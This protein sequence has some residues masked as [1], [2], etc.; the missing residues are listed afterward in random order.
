MA[1]G[2]LDISIVTDHLLDELRACR[3]D[4]AFW[5][6][7]FADRFQITV[8]GAAPDAVPRDDGCQLG[9]YLFH[10]DV[11]RQHRNSFPTGGEAQRVPVQPMALVLHYL[12]SAVSS[13]GYVDEQQAMSIGLKCF[14]ERPFKD[15]IAPDGTRQRVTITLDPRTPD[16]A[17]R[18]WQA[19]AKPMR[20]S[21]A[22]RVGVTLLEPP[23]EP[24]RPQPVLDPRLVRP[25]HTG[26]LTER[27]V[28][29]FH[30]R[31]RPE[32]VLV[33]A[34]A[35]GFLTLAVVGVAA[36]E[37]TVFVNRFELMEFAGGPLGFGQFAV[38]APDTLQIRVHDVARS[39]RYPL[40]VVPT[41][42]APSVEF[43]LEVA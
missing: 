29:A 1:L 21:T 16:D 11:D 4:P 31:Q 33:S 36:G 9:M 30:D 5:G 22:Y 13:D 8:T 28:D 20:L 18:L 43:T 6:A 34:D 12:L 37:T 32:P 2:I 19:T 23:S 3:D 14:H 15:V 26:A 40:R 17:A 24:R 39:G 38:T 7:G 41:P 42:G 10:I 27:G 25:D 35:N